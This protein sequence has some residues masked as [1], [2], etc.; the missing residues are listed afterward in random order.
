M[1]SGRPRA[2]L[3]PVLMLPDYDRA[4]RIGEF[5]RHPESRTFAELLIQQSGAVVGGVGLAQMA[6]LVNGA[7]SQTV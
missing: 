1:P 5:W 6:L 3:L 2:E 7:S 4:D